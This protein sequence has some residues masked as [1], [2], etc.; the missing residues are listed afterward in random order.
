MNICEDCILYGRCSGNCD[1]ID[2]TFYAFE[3]ENDNYDFK[4]NKSC[5]SSRTFLFLRKV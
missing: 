1:D 3:K 5:R 2:S 4:N